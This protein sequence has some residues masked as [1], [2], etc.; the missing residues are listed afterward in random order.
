LRFFDFAG[1]LQ[2]SKNYLTGGIYG[3]FFAFFL[4]WEILFDFSVF[5]ALKNEKYYATLQ[6]NFR[7]KGKEML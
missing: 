5:F 6:W 1:A 4:F 3:S 2:W 7:N